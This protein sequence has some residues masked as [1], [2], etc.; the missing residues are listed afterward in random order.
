MDGSFQDVSKILESPGYVYVFRFT[1]PRDSREKEVIVLPTLDQAKEAVLKFQ[2]FGIEYEFN[3]VVVYKP[4][5]SNISFKLLQ[6]E[7]RDFLSGETLRLK[8]AIER[9]GPYTHDMYGNKIFTGGRKM[10][11]RSGRRRSM[12]RR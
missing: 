1:N 12:S 8:R 3:A 6:K 2:R 5:F 4:D 11:G 9:K 7:D 10:R